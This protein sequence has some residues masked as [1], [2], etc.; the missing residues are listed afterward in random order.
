MT[1]MGQT[2]VASAGTAAALPAGLLNGP[3]MVKA[4]PANNGL[5]AVG[6]GAGLSLSNGFLLAAGDALVLEFVARL[7]AVFVD[8]AMDG[9]G[10]CWI[11]L[12][13]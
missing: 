10:V 1:L 13:A 9:D 3:L 11:G 8:A 12:G 6:Y 5:V 2:M 4:L 7:E